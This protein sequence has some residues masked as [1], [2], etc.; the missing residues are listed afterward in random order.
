VG[1]FGKLTSVVFDISTICELLAKEDLDYTLKTILAHTLRPSLAF[2][3]MSSE[4]ASRPSNASAQINA[5][6]HK[7]WDLATSHLK[8]SKLNELLQ[9]HRDKP[10]IVEPLLRALL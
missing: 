10:L 2:I 5:V 6:F 8:I 1:V 3:K 7:Y 9:S 4:V